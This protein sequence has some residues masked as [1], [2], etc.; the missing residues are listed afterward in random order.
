MENASIVPRV[1][2]KRGSY[3]YVFQLVKHK[4]YTDCIVPKIYIHSNVFLAVISVFSYNLLL[5]EQILTII[6]KL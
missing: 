4:A 1:E 3:T 5:Q 2:I 6:Q